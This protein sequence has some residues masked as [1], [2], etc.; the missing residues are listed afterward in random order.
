MLNAF[1]RV[2]P[3]L[4]FRLF[5]IL[6]DG[7]FFGAIDFSLRTCAVVQARPFFPFFIRAFRMWA[8]GWNDD[9]LQHHV[10]FLSPERSRLRCQRTMKVLSRRSKGP[11][12]QPGLFF[13]L[14]QRE[15]I[16]RQEG[17]G[18]RAPNG[19]SQSS[20]VAVEVTCLGNIL[21]LLRRHFRVILTTRHT[22]RPEFSASHLVF[23]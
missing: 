2:A 13:S 16:E 9:A 17:I 14:Q 12:P 7:P 20:G 4:R 15:I 21:R 1:R 8:D 6:A 10:E 22:A 11:A 23:G 5:A 3:S 18:C 19:S